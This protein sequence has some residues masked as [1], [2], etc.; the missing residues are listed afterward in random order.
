MSEFFSAP[1]SG[2]FVVVVGQMTTFDF[3]QCW[4]PS[5]LPTSN[6][7]AAPANKGQQRRRRRRRRKANILLLSATAATVALCCNKNFHS[8]TST[9]MREQSQP[10]GLALVR[11]LACSL[12]ILAEQRPPRM[13]PPPSTICIVVHSNFACTPAAH[14]CLHC[15]LAGWLAGKC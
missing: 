10:V 3:V 4:P 2:V 14:N 7:S 15:L 8:S 11:L 6:V 12:V 1:L 5:S 13:Q 9:T